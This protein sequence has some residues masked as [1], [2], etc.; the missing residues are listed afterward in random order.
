V[1]L[2]ANGGPGWLHLVVLVCIWSALKMLWIGP[3][4]VGLHIR[5]RLCE[6][7]T[8]RRRRREQADDARRSTFV[9]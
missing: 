4:S 9:G 2:S 7:A 6:A 8:A 3:I 1:R 5:A